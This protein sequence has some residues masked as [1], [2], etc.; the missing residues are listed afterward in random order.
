[1]KLKSTGDE[2]A[3]TAYTIAVFGLGYVGCVSAAC[4]AEMGNQ[5]IGVDVNLHKVNLINRGIP[6]IVEKGIAELVA[7]QHKQ[8]R[9]SA[10]SDI[11]TAVAQADICL[12]CVGTPSDKSGYPDL[13]FIRHVADQIS[14]AIKGREKFQTII[15]R[16]TV[17][18]GTCREIELRIARSGKVVDKDFAVVS[19][20]EFL[21]EGTSIE[22]YF[23]PPYTLIGTRNEKALEML[24][25]IYSPIQ[26][27]IMETDREVAE[28]IK[29]VNNSFHAL[30]VV[31][32]NEIAA[33][34][35]SMNVDPHTLMNLFVK[36][37]HL[38]I[39]PAYLM[40]GFAYGGSCLPKDLKALN[41]MA[42]SRNVEL[43]V[44]SSVE[45]SNALLIEK[46]L[47]MIVA[48]G[49]VRVGVLGLAFKSGTDDLRESP[50]VKLLERLLGKGY[51]IKIYDSNVLTSQLVGANKHYI[52]S[53][54]PHLAKLLAPNLEEIKE[55]A[56]LIVVA[57][58][59]EENLEFVLDILPAK[60]VIDLV[61]IVD[62]KP[63]TDHY[64]GLIW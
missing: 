4:L 51:D 28:M 12:V 40:P 18:P 49:M 57:Q 3:M 30:K 48:E 44:L 32:A 54:V 56:D 42:R 6:T 64:K 20:P 8:G 14:D 23:N 19:N 46:A 15:I 50:V 11:Q 22:D 62:V 5:V 2:L 35:H 33:L 21:R 47:D 31:F 61:R 39:S 13:S 36:D 10:R 16:S 43:S 9:L 29:Y 45:R 27:P 37:R 41:A 52:E 25:N 1:M 34:C 7:E 38:N 60:Q 24:R 63:E 53:T 55:F 17:P 26:A 58:K 59:N